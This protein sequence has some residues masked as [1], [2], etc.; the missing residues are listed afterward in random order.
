MA[1]VC[2]S[3]DH[4]VNVCS[5]CGA[6]LSVDVTE[7][8]RRVEERAAEQVEKAA[9]NE[10]A[11]RAELEQLRRFVGIPAV[12]AAKRVQLAEEAAAGARLARDKAVELARSQR[13]LVEE[14]GAVRRELAQA[15]AQLRAAK[16]AP[17]VVDVLKLSSDQLGHV[18]RGATAELERRLAVAT[19]ADDADGED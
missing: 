6:A 3:C 13:G 11:A 2:T 15:Q 8:L 9:R 17:P 10:K 12:E 16:A 7:Q 1:I 18:I 14:L 19:G 4:S 5:H